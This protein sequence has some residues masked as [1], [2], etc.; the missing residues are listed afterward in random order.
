[1]S[2]GNILTPYASFIQYTQ[3]CYTINCD[4]GNIESISI[5]NG[6]YIELSYEIKEIE[7]SVEEKDPDTIAAKQ[8]WLNAK[9]QWLETEGDFESTATERAAA[10]ALIDTTYDA[11]IT[12]LKAALNNN[13]YKEEIY[14]V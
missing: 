3:G 6:I 11:Y 7:Y 5:D 4:F 1:L 12:A 13:I 2:I 9:K 8:A 14:A 10:R